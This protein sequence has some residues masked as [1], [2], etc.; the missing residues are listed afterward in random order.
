MLD[1]SQCSV[2]LENVFGP[3]V[4]SPCLH[5][6]DFTL[7][8]EETIL[9]LLPFGLVSLAAAVRIWKL[10]NALEKINRSWS[11]AAKEVICQAF[12]NAFFTLTHT[13]I[14]ATLHLI[15]CGVVGALGSPKH[16]Q[17]RGNSIY[18]DCHDRNFVGFAL[19][20][21]SGAPSLHSPIHD[22]ECL[23]F[24]YTAV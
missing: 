9:T 23:S 10:H 5:G 18:G 24:L 22:S 13:V 19:S 21:P 16:P 12:R 14:L 11:Y 1:P 2:E 8:F 7:L 17:D 20:L 6:F 15:A 3:I 4:A